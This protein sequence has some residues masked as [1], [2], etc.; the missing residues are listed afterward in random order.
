MKILIIEDNPD[1]LE[2]IIDALHSITEVTIVTT[3]ALT[4]ADGMNLLTK[5]ILE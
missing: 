1:H 5:P 3:S 4:M 2:L